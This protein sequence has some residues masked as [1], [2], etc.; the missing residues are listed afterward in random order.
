MGGVGQGR[1]VLILGLVD[2]S[3]LPRRCTICRHILPVIDACPLRRRPPSWRLAMGYLLSLV[4]TCQ[5]VDLLAHLRLGWRSLSQGVVHAINVPLCPGPA[6]TFLCTCEDTVSIAITWELSPVVITNS[7]PWVVVK[8]KTC[9]LFLSLRSLRR[10]VRQ[11][12]RRPLSRFSIKGRKLTRWSSRRLE[13]SRLSLGFL[14][15]APQGVLTLSL[16][17]CFG[18]K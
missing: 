1:G 11:D 8:F 7:D 6:P 4:K 2:V 10:P 17:A 9:L 13:L 18:R 5:D 3:M 15:K 14:T 12:C 16:K